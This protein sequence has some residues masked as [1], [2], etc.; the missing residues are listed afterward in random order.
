MCLESPDSNDRFRTDA[1]R[2]ALSPR[3]TAELHYER[4]APPTN[5]DGP[6]YG[7]KRFEAKARLSGSAARIVSI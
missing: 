5:F 4:F 7:S 6:V 2:T 1:L 3:R